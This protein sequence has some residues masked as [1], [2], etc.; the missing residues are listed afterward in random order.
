MLIDWFTVGAQLLNFAILVWLL[1]H[2]LYRPILTAIDAREKRIAAESADAAAKQV[3]A[4]QEHAS[5]ELKSAAFD[6][7]RA[8]LLAQAT[9]DANAQR[10][11]L[12]NEARESAAAL[13]ATQAKA[14]LR[15]QQN[16]SA[17]LTRLASDEVFAI[18]RRALRDL[19]ATDLEERI[20]AIFTRRLGALDADARTTLAGAIRTS[21]EPALLRTG[22]AL[23]PTERATVQ[24]ALNETFAADVRVRYET[25]P[26]VICGIE[27]SVG[28]Q[29]LGWSI[30]EYLATLEQK[31]GALLDAQAPLAAPAA[32]SA[33]A[34]APS[35]AAVAAATPD[36]RV[37]SAVTP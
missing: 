27:L 16:L 19:A 26:T 9:A 34:L 28:G 30:A 29:K 24:N 8:A 20:G 10:E 3:A 11:R 14:L 36:A 22:F 1:R 32:A 13:R 18:A 33:P 21:A 17:A 31:F 5:F 25:A 12:L 7:Q 35:P 2:F 23:P 4:S 15:E 6:Q 37:A